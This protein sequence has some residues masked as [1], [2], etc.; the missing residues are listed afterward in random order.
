M[1]RSTVCWDPEPSRA[2]C[3]V[4]LDGW[5]SVGRSVANSPCAIALPVIQLG[6][7]WHVEAADAD[8]DDGKRVAIEQASAGRI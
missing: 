2:G 1:L 7:L 8:A 6:V 3:R 5:R 4:T